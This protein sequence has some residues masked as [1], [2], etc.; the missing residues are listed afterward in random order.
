[1]KGRI[2]DP[3][4]A[5]FLTTDPLVARPG[6]SQ[7]WNPYSY[8]M[9]SPLKFVDPTGFET[10]DTTYSNGTREVIFDPDPLFASAP[11][12]RDPSVDSRPPRDSDEVN[13]DTGSRDAG[14]PVSDVMPRGED[15]RDPD[16]VFVN[17]PED[18]RAPSKPYD[19]GNPVPKTV[20]IGVLIAG[21]IV[22]GTLL[23]GEETIGNV[24]EGLGL[25]TAAPK[26]PSLFIR[27][28]AEARQQVKELH[29]FRPPP[30][31]MQRPGHARSSHGWNVND[32]R[33]LTIR[34]GPDRIYVGT[35]ASGNHVAVFL[36]G[37]DVV[38]TDLGDT[39]SVITA[40]GE[41]APRRPSPV[42]DKWVEDPSFHLVE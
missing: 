34:N 28:A 4:L 35:N 13:R 30:G 23:L 25:A 27:G 26:V 38:I 29:D 12:A 11:P 37:H 19:F 42:P 7:S 16:R 3:R 10:T 20:G 39:Q 21:P 6:F 41:N 32:S 2:F 1:M 17:E 9:N 31:S 22:L 8:V 15:H 24:A 40:Y 33:I 18:E 36:K 5:R 14:Q